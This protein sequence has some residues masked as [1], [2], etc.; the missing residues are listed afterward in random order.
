MATDK[1]IVSRWRAYTG[2]VVNL[3]WFNGGGPDRG[4][5]I[6]AVR[7]SLGITEGYSVVLFM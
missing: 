5:A 2:G 4:Q 6:H 7:N 3:S 1:N